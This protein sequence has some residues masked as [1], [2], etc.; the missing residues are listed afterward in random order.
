MYELLWEKL[1]GI[2]KDGPLLFTFV[3]HE[4]RAFSHHLEIGPFYS[5]FVFS[6]VLD[7]FSRADEGLGRS[8]EVVDLFKS[9]VLKITCVIF[10]VQDGGAYLL[11]ID[12]PPN[13]IYFCIVPF[14]WGFVICV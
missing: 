3:T 12:D 4:Y 13:Y 1:S 9:K 5:E 2:M 7:P 6:S 11:G 14:F 8:R 10:Q